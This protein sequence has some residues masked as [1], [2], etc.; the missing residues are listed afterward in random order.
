[1]S[2]RFQGPLHEPFDFA[3]GGFGQMTVECFGAI[4]TERMRM[5]PV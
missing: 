5:P 2:F 1:M 3:S 4:S